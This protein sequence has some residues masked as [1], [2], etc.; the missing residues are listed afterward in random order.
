[1]YKSAAGVNEAGIPSLLHEVLRTPTS[2]AHTHTHTLVSLAV[3]VTEVSNVVLH[4]PVESVGGLEL[5]PYF[6]NKWKPKETGKG[7]PVRTCNSVFTWT[8]K[9]ALIP[10]SNTLLRDDT[11]YM[12]F[13]CTYDGKAN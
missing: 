5:V 1:M 7:L 8:G 10:P 9:S 13:I 2:G 11:A 6:R 3:L 12:Y 4:N